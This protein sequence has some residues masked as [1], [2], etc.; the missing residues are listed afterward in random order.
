MCVLTRRFP[1]CVCWLV[2]GVLQ[3]LKELCAC[4]LSSGVDVNAMPM[5]MIRAV[6]DLRQ[7]AAVALGNI[8]AHYPATQIAGKHTQHRPH[9]PALATCGLRPSKYL[10]EQLRLW[11][12]QHAESLFVAVVCVRCVCSRG[13]EL[14]VRVP[15]HVPLR[16][17]GGGSHHQAMYGTRAPH[18]AKHL[19]VCML[20]LTSMGHGCVMGD[21]MQGTVVVRSRGWEC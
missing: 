17:T 20:W 15:R 16:P 10:W 4:L 8:V 18:W 9:A 5:D 13:C 1:A 2:C 11:P 12:W 14:V 19:P 21:V 3:T 7:R 6:L